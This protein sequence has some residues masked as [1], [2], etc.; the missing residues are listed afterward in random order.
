[1]QGSAASNENSRAG[2]QCVNYSNGTQ[3]CVFAGEFIVYRKLSKS[4]HVLQ[5]TIAELG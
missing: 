4:K 1:M 5:S 3:A 2:T